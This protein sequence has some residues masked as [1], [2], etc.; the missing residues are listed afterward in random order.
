MAYFVRE[1]REI[2]IVNA[3]N[4]KSHIQCMSIAVNFVIAVT[5][6]L[7]S[8]CNWPVHASVTCMYL[9]P[10]ADILV[11]DSDAIACEYSI[12]D[13]SRILLQIWK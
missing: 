13:E 7:P 12:S 1:E 2:A 5:L 9:H 11:E 10:I 4:Q 3:A 8:A 6:L